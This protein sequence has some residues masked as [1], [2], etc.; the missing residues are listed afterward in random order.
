MMTNFAERHIRPAVILR[1]N[2]Q[3]N[4]SA[5]GAAIQSAMM[6]V[7]VA[8]D[9]IRLTPSPT[10]SATSSPPENCRPSP[11]ETL[12]VREALQKQ[13]TAGLHLPR[14]RCSLLRVTWCSSG[15]GRRYDMRAS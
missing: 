13:Q 12:P 8:A 4:R 7:A 11:I 14:S 6:S 3:N 2:G 10:P 5:E 9:T 15:E 1:E